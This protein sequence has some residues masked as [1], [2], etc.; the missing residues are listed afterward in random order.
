M[1]YGVRILLAFLALAVIVIAWFASLV[2]Y[3][4]MIWR[5]IEPPTVPRLHEPV[6]N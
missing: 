5:D 4:L 1:A 6:T 3:A 2:S